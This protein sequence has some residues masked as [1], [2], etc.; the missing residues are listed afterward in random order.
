MNAKAGFRAAYAADRRLPAHD[1]AID[2][3]TGS[4]ERA[5]AGCRHACQMPLT[6]MGLATSVALLVDPA[7]PISAE[8]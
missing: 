3:K 5:F 2:E 4:G 6:A 8:T 7:K 1:L